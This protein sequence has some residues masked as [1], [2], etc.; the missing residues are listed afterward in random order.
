MVRRLYAYVNS[1][2]ANAQC[3]A[4]CLCSNAKTALFVLAAWNVKI[5]SEVRQL[6]TK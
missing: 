6:Y 5:F 2:L 4:I 1:V 3:F